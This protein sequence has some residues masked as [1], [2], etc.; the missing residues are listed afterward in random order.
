MF[1]D[2]CTK[3]LQG[4]LFSKFCDVIMGWKNVYTLQMG[5]PSTNERVGNVVKI[6]LNQKEIK[7][8]METVGER[9]ESILGIEGD[10]TGYN[11][12]TK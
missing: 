4:S 10:K 11:V 12:E 9:I 3:S 8:N 5:P 7:S 2:F 6:R 1:T